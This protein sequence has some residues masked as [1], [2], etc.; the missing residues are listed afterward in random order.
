M[1]QQKN[2]L[3]RYLVESYN[4]LSTQL[5]ATFLHD[6]GNE[7]DHAIS[8]LELIRRTRDKR[9]FNRENEIIENVISKLIFASKHLRKFS[10]FLYHRDSPRKTRIKDQIESVLDLTQSIAVKRDVKIESDIINCQH[11]LDSKYLPPLLYALIINAVEAYSDFTGR[12]KAKKVRITAESINSECIIRVTD[13][14]QG[15]E[16]SILEKIFDPGMTTKRDNRGMGLFIAKEAAEWYGGSITVKSSPV[17]AT[18]FMVKL[19]INT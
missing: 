3:D 6:H 14:G 1:P 13:Y 17:T 9:H 18:E 5:F 4:S 15:I 7:L 12:S 16:E 8:S 10:A 2:E 11:I 19:P